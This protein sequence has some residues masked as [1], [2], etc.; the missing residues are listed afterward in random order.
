MKVEGTYRIPATPER[1]WQTL[2]DPE[3]LKLAIPGCEELAQD[4]ENSYR[5]RMRAGVAAIKSTFTGEVRLQDLDPPRRYRMV[6]S[7]RGTAGFVN[8]VGEIELQP[9]RG[10]TD[11]VYRGEVQVGGMLAAIGSRMIEAAFRKSVGDFFTTVAKRL[12]ADS[13]D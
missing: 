3:F 2:L 8:G 12:N 11:V 6:T 13:A 4:G 7:A 9:Q 1:V 10:E 5:M